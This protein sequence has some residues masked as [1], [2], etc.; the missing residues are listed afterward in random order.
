MRPVTLLFIAP[1]RTLRRTAHAWRIIVRASSGT[2]AALAPYRAP[3]AAQRPLSAREQTAPACITWRWRRGIA[4]HRV[5]SWRRCARQPA[6][7]NARRVTSSLPIGMC[8]IIF[9]RV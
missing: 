1:S 2:R 3:H 4:A 5:A 7:Y 6:A 8:A 9:R